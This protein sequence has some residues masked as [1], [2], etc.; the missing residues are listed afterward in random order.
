MLVRSVRFTDEPLGMSPTEMD[1]GDYRVVAGVK[2]PFPHHL[3]LA[4][5]LRQ[6]GPDPDTAECN[7][8]R[9][10]VWES[11]SAGAH[12]RQQEVSWFRVISESGLRSRAE[13][14][15]FLGRRSGISARHSGGS[16][17]VIEAR[18]SPLNM[19]GILSAC[20]WLEHTGLGDRYSPAQPG[21]FR[22][23]RPSTC[24]ESCFW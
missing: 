1:Y 3:H 16:Q 13:A 2:M 6:Y 18:E 12:Q 9:G 22:S 19:P 24:L 23:S 5:W 4:G 8:R 20:D 21:C 7:D 17:V 11:R 15:F 10:E 14:A